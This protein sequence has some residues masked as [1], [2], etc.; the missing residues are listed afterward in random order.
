MVSG[1]SLSPLWPKG[2]SFGLFL[3]HDIDQIYDRELFRVLADINHGRRMITDGEEG[4]WYYLVRRIGRSI[5]R[6]KLPIRDFTTILELEARYGFRSTFFVL[7]DKRLSRRGGRY[8]LSDPA[9]REIVNLVLES[10]GEIGVHGAFGDLDNADAYAQCRIN[11]GEAFGVEPRGI[12]NHFLRFSGKATWQAQVDAGFCY[13]A[14]FADP[15]KLGNRDGHSGPF[16][17]GAKNRS[18]RELLELPLTV[19]DTSLFRCLRIPDAEEAV[20]TAWSVIEPI[21]N[22]GGLVSLL[23]HNNFFNE[24]EYAAWQES[25]SWLLARLAKHRPYCGN[26]FEIYQLFSKHAE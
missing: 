19:M 26:G 14:T 16:W 8:R 1:S 10:G 5:L 23:W 3:S 7:D 12:R 13:D 24:P 15:Y 6:P 17:T 11:I 18:G 4:D 25:Y 22:V 21:I 20:E 9:L 2:H